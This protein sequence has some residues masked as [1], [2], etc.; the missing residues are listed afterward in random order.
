L[1]KEELNF[2]LPK[3]KKNSNYK[4]QKKKEKKQK[5]KASSLCKNSQ[6]SK[7]RKNQPQFSKIE[8]RRICSL[9][10]CIIEKL[11]VSSSIKAY[12]KGLKGEKKIK[13]WNLIINQKLEEVKQYEIRR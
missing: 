9:I 12:I 8:A 13:A 11:P 10:D 5:T 2:I 4:S 6:N 3:N 1:K 7:I